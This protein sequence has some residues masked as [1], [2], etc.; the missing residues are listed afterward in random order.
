MKALIEFKTFDL[1][2]K[3]F[4]QIRLGFLKESDAKAILNFH[5]AENN[6][7]VSLFTSGLKK[8]ESLSEK[9]FE[10]KLVESFK[11]VNSEVLQVLIFPVEYNKTYV[12]RVYLK[13]E[14][15]GKSFIVDYTTK[16]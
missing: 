7:F 8:P 13:N 10:N 14:E 16:R 2:I 12:A 11:R 1:T 6:S 5:N 9:Q 3:N 4:E 15:A